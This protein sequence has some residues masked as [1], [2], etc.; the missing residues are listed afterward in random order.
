MFLK[1]NPM[2]S[3]NFYTHKK[4]IIFIA[5]LCSFLWGSAYPSIKIGYNILNILADDIPSKL[6]FAGYRF[7]LAGI[8]VLLVYLLINKTLELPDKKNLPSIFILGL[9]QTTLQYIFFY[10]GLSHTTG[11]NGAIL[12][13]VGTF[14][15]VILAHY[16]Y[17]NDKLNHSKTIGCIVGFLGILIMNYSK[18]LVIFD[19]NFQGDGFVIIAALIS[20]GASIYSKKLCNTINAMILTGFQLFIGGLFLVL[21][22]VVSGGHLQGFTL[23][24]SMLLLYMGFLSAAAFTLWTYL[25]KYNKVGKISVYSF[26][27]PIFGAIL[28]SVLLKE[29]FLNAK[30]LTALCLV[31]VGI[32]I[33]NNTKYADS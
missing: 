8:L 10:I 28:S 4:N 27:I 6:I 32:Y 13:S 20:S 2:D 12:N 25:L 9:F 22:G 1:R 15:S 21:L 19:F 31:C 33:V 17:K 26:L 5:V 16:I 14:F 30:N 29:N 18:D 7:T 3:L 23:T 24:A 11:V